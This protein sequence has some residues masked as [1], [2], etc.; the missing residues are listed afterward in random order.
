MQRVERHPAAGGLQRRAIVALVGIAHGQQ[1]KAFRQLAPQGFGLLCLPIVEG[2]AIAQGKA[3][4]EIATVECGCFGQAG[5]AA[6]AGG[7]GR[8]MV[9]AR[10]S[11]QPP[12]AVDIQRHLVRQQAHLIAL[13]VQPAI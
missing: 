10:R 6:W 4:H 1:L 9:L 11:D 7:L 12:K 13:R 8:W 2:R 3:A 5:Q